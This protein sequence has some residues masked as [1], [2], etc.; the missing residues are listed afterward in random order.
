MTVPGGHF[1][2]PVGRSHKYPAF[3]LI[4][5]GK[6]HYLIVEYDILTNDVHNRPLAW[7]SSQND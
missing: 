6:D 7:P 4:F 2:F 5:S 1:T 3:R